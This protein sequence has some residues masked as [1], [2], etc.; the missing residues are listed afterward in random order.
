MR[1]GLVTNWDDMERVW[2]HCFYNEIKLC[3]EEHPILVVASPLTPRAD[4]EKITQIMFET[5]NVPALF[6]ACQSFLALYESGR[7]T[8]VVVES[9]FESSRAIPIFEGYILMHSLSELR[10]GGHDLTQYFATMLRDRGCC[11]DADTYEFA[12]LKESHCYVAL[13]FQ[14]ELALAAQDDYVE[15]V[16]PS[17]KGEI[18]TR[19]GSERFR[20]PEALFQPSML[21]MEKDGIH[22]HVAR[23]ITNCEGALREMLCDC[24]LLSGGST[25]FPGMGA[26][27]TQELNTLLS[28]QEL[29]QVI[30]PPNRKYSAWIGASRLAST[31]GFLKKCIQKRDYDEFGPTLIHLRCP[32][33]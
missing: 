12:W 18:V 29:V 6:I 9:T 21:G 16:D 14:A 1:H 30:S 11:P 10:L 19:L 13:D 32:F 31:K 24:I 28:G 27:L 7:T 20:C 8:G 4:Q 26:R 25:M 15:Y 2:H 3:V 33:A 5:F 17:P 23:S 22:I